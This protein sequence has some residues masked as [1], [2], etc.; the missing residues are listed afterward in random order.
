MFNLE[1]IAQSQVSCAL[2]ADNIMKELKDSKEDKQWRI[3][4]ELALYR[5]IDDKMKVF[6]EERKEYSDKQATL[7]A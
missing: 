7:I 2:V 4:Q 1:Q 3:D 5:D 6:K